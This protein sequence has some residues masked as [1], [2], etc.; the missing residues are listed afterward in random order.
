MNF[1]KVFKNEIRIVGIAIRTTNQNGQSRTDLSK[2]WKRFESDAIA[3]KIPH[4]VSND[5]FSVY[6]DYDSDFTQPYTALIGCEVKDFSQIPSGM[7]SKTIPAATYAVFTAKGKLP[8]SILE[9]WK[10]VW[11]FDL[12]RAYTGDFEVYGEKSKAADTEV[13]VFVSVKD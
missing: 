5:V 1:T 11:S 7:V 13:E 4:K 3:S 12:P 9:V 10:Y 2:L 6:I 8:Q